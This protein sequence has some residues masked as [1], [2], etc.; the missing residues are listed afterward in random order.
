VRA[1]YGPRRARAEV[2]RDPLEVRAVVLRA[3][4]RG[5]ALVLADL[6]LVPEDLDEALDARLADLGLDVVLVATH[7]H[8]SVGGFDRRLLAQFV[9]TGR[10]REDVVAAVLDRSEEAVRQAAARLVPVQVYTGER[11]LADWAENRS[12]PGAPIDDVLTVAA[13]TAV[14]GAPVATLAIAA[15]HPTLHPRTVPELTADYPG[16]AM[17]RLAAGGAPALLFQGAHGDARPLGSG[18]AAI[19]SAGAFVAAQVAE[20]ATQARVAP[21]RLAFAEAE[22]ALPRAE[23]QRARSFFVRRPAS[24]LLQW[25]A[26]S[27]SRVTVVTLGDLTLL[28]VPGE[29]TAEAARRI[30]AAIPRSGSDDRRFRVFSLAQ[31]YVGYVE[32]PERVSRGEGEGRRAWFAPELLE[33]VTRGLQAGVAAQ[34]DE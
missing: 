10:Y 34:R 4:D 33:V 24:N 12:T 11:R 23:L 25:L 13:L 14:G 29:P 20:T 32:T 17:R 31:G 2:E 19:E 21:V 5:L 26:P 27:R 7:T 28:G 1:G 30:V 16:V 8:S 9:G 22:I 18:R 6:V 15:A 3:A